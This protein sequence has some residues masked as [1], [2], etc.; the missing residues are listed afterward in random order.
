MT[1]HQIRK[2]ALDQLRPGMFVGNVFNERG[3]LLYSANTLIRDYAQ[4]EALR[5]Q[6]VIT[7]SINLNKGTGRDLPPE[8]YEN[9]PQEEP[10]QVQ[11]VI[12]EDVFDEKKVQR[13]M[14][15]RTTIIDTVQE[16]MASARTGRLFSITSITTCVE[17]IIDVMLDE[18][19]LLL[20]LSRMKSQ[21][22]VTYEHSVNVA[23]LMVGFSA[24]LG[25]SRSRILDV[26]TG[27]MLHD[28]G[29]VKLPEELLHKQGTCTRRE[30]ELFKRHPAFGLEIIDHNGKKTPPVIRNIISQHHE[31]LNGSGYPNRLRG[32]QIDEVALICAIADMYDSLTTQGLHHKNYIPQ[33]ALALIF[34]G[35]DDDYPRP[36]VE[37]FTKLLGIYP[38]GSF[39]KLD[40]GEM[41]V[42]V[43]NNRQKLLT[44]LVKVLFDGQGIRLETPY[45]NDLSVTDNQF[46]RNDVRIIHSLDPFAFNVTTDEFFRRG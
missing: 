8:P 38:V 10:S 9:E 5:R 17:S 21:S 29:K 46:E 42:V 43:K 27:G 22:T 3:V 18:P 41:G 1:A 14:E 2:I 12:D 30:Y 4:I 35:A 37:H 40:S 25:F 32:R 6:G 45:L 24:A 31:R 13:V 16:V 36:M 28:I 44:P 19:D 7:V 11:N 33:E 20:S 23:V 34:Q 15:M 39:V 26:G